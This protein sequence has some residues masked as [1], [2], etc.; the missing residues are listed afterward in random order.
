MRTVAHMVKGTEKMLLSLARFG[1]LTAAQVTRL[2]FA[3]GSRTYVHAGLKSLVDAGFAVALGGRGTHLPYVYTPTGTGYTVA[4]TL[5]GIPQ[6]RRV[7]SREE[8]KKAANQYFLQHT[9]AV[10]DVLIA[11]Q[12]L[13]H[14]VPDIT[15]NRLYLE[16][17]LKRKIYV[18]HGNAGTSLRDSCLEPDAAVEF[19]LQRKWRE[20]F[21]IEVYRTHLREERFKHKIHTYAAYA[22]SIRHQELFQ[23]SALAIAMFCTDDHLTETLKQW[24]EEVLQEGQQRELGERFFFSSVNP[25]TAKPQEIFLSPVWEHAF[26]TDK[27]PLLVLE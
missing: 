22:A 26:S 10:S 21:H 15:L 17:E 24:T 18:P 23:T 14:T 4:S 20:F 27:T 11:A 6:R 8:E 7:R 13:S 12:L 5:L 1:Y 19:L 25:A 16:R 2:C 9:I 3:T